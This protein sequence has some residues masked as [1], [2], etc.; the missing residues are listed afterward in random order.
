MPGAPNRPPERTDEP[1]PPAP[2]AEPADRPLR[3]RLIASH[4]ALL[5]DGWKGAP[6]PELIVPFEKAEAALAAGDLPTAT[7][8]LDQLS[9]RFAEPRWPTLPAPFRDLRVAIPAPMPPH[10]DPESKLEPAARDAVRARRAAEGQL[11]LAEA[12]V[13][14]AGRHGLAADDLAAPLAEAKALLAEGGVPAGYYDRLDRVWTTLAG[15]LPR[16]KASTAR[17]APAAESAEA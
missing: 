15:R 1:A 8:A 6:S 13:A 9:I 5:Q 4:V 16:P 2:V 14:W 3:R 10:W 17:P 12:S 11:L 7:T